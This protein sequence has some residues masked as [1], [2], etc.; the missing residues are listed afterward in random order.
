MGFERWGTDKWTLGGL[1]FILQS[2]TIG[3]DTNLK[4]KKI[5]HCEMKSYLQL[6]GLHCFTKFEYR[7][8]MIL[9]RIMV[10]IQISKGTYGDFLH[11]KVVMLGP[12]LGHEY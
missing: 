4:V 5:S 2:F 6:E 12:K 11:T 7:N 3:I 8:L 9:G 1:C 10:L